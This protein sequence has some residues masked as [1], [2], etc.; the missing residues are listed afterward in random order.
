MELF[1][2]KCEFKYDSNVGT[3]LIFAE[4]KEEAENI[5]K[6]YCY[7]NYG[8]NKSDIQIKF[9]GKEYI[10]KGVITGIDF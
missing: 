7:I 1:L 9:T 3:K 4:S 10:N 8:I 5:L 6:K 2:Y